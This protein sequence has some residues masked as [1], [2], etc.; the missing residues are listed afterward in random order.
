MNGF[1]YRIFYKDLSYIGSTT[2]LKQRMVNHISSND[3][4]SKEIICYN[5]EVEILAE[6]YNMDDKKILLKLER[7]YMEQYKCV[8]KKKSILLENDNHYLENRDKM[9]EKQKQYYLKNPD[10]CKEVMKKY[11]IENKEKYNVYQKQYR[12]ENKEKML[13]YQKQY[14]KNKEK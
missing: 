6:I 2:N 5:Y 12:I 14:Y 1:V 9:L 8:N 4:S 10:K 7:E 3:C 11:K 13:S